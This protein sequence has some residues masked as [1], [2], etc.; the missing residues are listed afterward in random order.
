MSASLVKC[1]SCDEIVPE[2]ATFC[3]RCGLPFYL[4]TRYRIIGVLS[5][6]EASE[7]FKAE[8][9]LCGKQIVTIK[10]F[11]SGQMS[12]EHVEE[13]Y[14][15]ELEF[16][17]KMNHH[18]IPKLYNHFVSNESW[19]LVLSFIE[20][21]TLAH[22]WSRARKETR[23]T[24][25]Q[26]LDIGIQLCHVLLYL[27]TLPRPIVFRDLNPSNIVL[28]PS[29]IQEEEHFHIYLIDFEGACYLDAAREI[30]TEIVG[31]RG[32]MAP[33]VAHRRASLLSD[34]Y[35]LGAVLFQLLA[36][37]KP[38]D[39]TSHYRRF[40]TVN[41]FPQQ[42]SDELWEVIKRMMEEDANDRP[43]TI[44][45]VRDELQA[46][47][48]QSPAHESER[49]PL[50]QSLTHRRSLLLAGAAGISGLVLGGVLAGTFLQLRPHTFTTLKVGSKLDNE[51]L[52][53]GEMYLLLLQAASYQ[54]IDRT[55]T[56]QS[57]GIFN[58]LMDGDIDVYPE[59][60]Q[61]G[62][63]QLHM[64]SK[65]DQQRDWLV[66][67]D[68]YQK[69]YHITWLT[70]AAQLNDNYCVAMPRRKAQGAGLKSLSDLA[71]YNRQ[72]SLSVAVAPDGMDAA[73]PLLTQA[74]GLTFN[75]P[76]A[77]SEPQSF[78]DVVTNVASLNICYSTDP[79]LTRFEFLRFLDDKNALPADS[80]SPII[81]IDLLKIAPDIDAI[82]RP[83]ASFLTTDAS[84]ELQ[85]KL[86]S[87]SVSN[88]RRQSAARQVARDWLQSKGLL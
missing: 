6:G 25:E 23:L 65:G 51:A 77:T 22:R 60:S 55:L 57:V 9:R 66:V 24:L 35:S 18:S 17:A 86:P 74:Y 56:G 28:A 52:L 85:G 78:Q 41:T 80:P 7:V 79:L 70:M 10:R 5:R 19:Y 45:E 73:I 81:R 26:T 12:Q 61:A 42:G 33:E 11:L 63:A 37:R 49:H 15:R 83:L 39:R 31:T 3:P 71:A 43:H 87:P 16:L 46:I 76:Y 32:Y 82:L 8:D 75:Y 40:S 48:H 84:T 36:G 59:Y 54:V 53:L 68:A 14:Q 62:L 69:D 29:S 50:Q 21:E 47:V 2:Q 4:D 38:T 72:H 58:A 44:A 67:N 20:G 13:R 30:S 64:R 27:H 88:E 1:P 34:I